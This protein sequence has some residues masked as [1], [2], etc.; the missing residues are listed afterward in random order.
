MTLAVDEPFLLLL[1]VLAPLPVIASVL[2]R[3]GYPSFDGLPRD[4]LSD[5]AGVVLR[6]LPCIA[7]VAIVFG[8]AGLHAGG[9]AVERVGYGA[10]IVLLL[11]RSSS[12]DNS[13][14]NRQPSGDE[15][16]KSAAARRLLEAFV[17]SRPH[18]LIEVDAFSTAPMLVLPLTDRRDAVFAAIRAVDR[19]GLAYTDVGRG[20]A[21]AVDA[22]GNEPG[23]AARAIILVSDGAGVIDRRVQDALR[24]AF[25][26][27][28]ARLYW[29]FLRTA[30]TR[31]IHEPPEPG[32]PD[33]PQALPERHL[34]LF[35]KGLAIPY[36]AFEAESPQAVADAIREID[37]LERGPMRIV[38]RTPRLDLAGAAYVIAAA[39]VALLCVA[40]LA[41]RRL[42]RP[43]GDAGAGRTT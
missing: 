2:R 29:L 17:R 39:A 34:D 14:A 20:L 5:A 6:L 43:S 7:I 26:R 11:D 31:G 38:E 21:M 41:E 18:D 9:R 28:R 15:E 19:P 23:D 4:P 13:F 40:K 42:V 24:A 37:A 32:A 30:G 1:L 22:F 10:H 27:T 36:R 16:S 3:E 35:F 33:T 12:M 8:I 25:H